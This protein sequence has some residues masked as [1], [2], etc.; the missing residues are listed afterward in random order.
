[1][2]IENMT[3]HELRD[4]ASAIEA[5]ALR[6]AQEAMTL[7]GK[8]AAPPRHKNATYIGKDRFFSDDDF[9]AAANQG[10]TPA[11]ASRQIGCHIS[12]VLQKAKTLGLAYPSGRRG[13]SKAL[14]Q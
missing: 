10:L 7:V 8:V 14:A 9:I 5:E 13:K 2:N 12:Y 1:V 4:L 6:R 3:I 11:E